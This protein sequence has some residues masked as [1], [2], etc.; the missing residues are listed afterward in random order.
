MPDPLK[1]TI[2]A[3]EAPGLFNVSPYVTRWMLW[4]KFANGIEIDSAEDNRMSWGKKMQ[5]LLLQ[6]AAEDLKLEV[7]PNDGDDYH[8][9]GLLGCTRDATIVCPDRGPGALETKCVFDYRVWMDKWQGGNKPPK[10]YEIQLQ[11]QMIVGDGSEGAMY[12]WGVIAAWVCGDM[13]Y[14]EREPIYDLMHRLNDEAHS[15]FKSVHRK[16]EPA[17]FGATVE[18]EW[19]TKLLPVVERKVINLVDSPAGR[20]YV[21]IAKD[22]LAAR[23][24]ASENTKIAEP[25]RAK[26]L[27]LAMD[28]QEV[29]LPEMI[30]VQIGGGA[31]AKRLNVFIPENTLMAG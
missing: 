2:S 25:L 24:A 8:R 13:Y 14:F 17:P 16:E 11:Q 27:A 31:K 29:W 10:E 7:I 15:F 23:T 18:I 12:E 4:Q 26:L 6:Q 19:L 28:A 22:Y 9:R 30:R 1:K 3:T 20:E 5:P 21:Q